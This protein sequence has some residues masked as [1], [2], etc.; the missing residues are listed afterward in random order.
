MLWQ[1]W[2]SEEHRKQQGGGSSDALPIGRL[3]RLTA[4]TLY[5]IAIFMSVA[6]L[7]LDVKRC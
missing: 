3:A 4:F 1:Y 7:Y 2:R 5:R 6:S